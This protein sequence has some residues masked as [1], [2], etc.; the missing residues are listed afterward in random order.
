MPGSQHE[1]KLE[2]GVAL[3]IMN[4]C[5]FCVVSKTCTQTV[6]VMMVHG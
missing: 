1:V 4:L 6:S 3:G 5:V 2:R